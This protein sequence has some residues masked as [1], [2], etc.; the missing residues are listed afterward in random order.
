M[1]KK[2]KT[3]KIVK[4]VSFKDDD[5]AISKGAAA[6]ITVAAGVGLVGAAA[7]WGQGHGPFPLVQA[8]GHAIGDAISPPK[9][10]PEQK[11]DLTFE[12]GKAYTLS[13]SEVKSLDPKWGISKDA[14]SLKVTPYANNTASVIVEKQATDKSIATSQAFVDDANAFLDDAF[15]GK[16]IVK[17][18]H[19]I[20]TD[21]HI[22]LTKE[23]A[24]NYVKGNLSN[25]KADGVDTVDIFVNGYNGI[26][27]AKIFYTNDIPVKVALD[28]KQTNAAIEGLA[29]NVTK[30]VKANKLNIKAVHDNP[31]AYLATMQF[32]ED[33]LKVSDQWGL[34]L[35]Q[36][37]K[38]A[39]TKS[40]KYQAGYEAGVTDGFFNGTW[41]SGVNAYA[42]HVINLLNASTNASLHAEINNVSKQI[43]IFKKTGD[44]NATINYLTDLTQK[45]ARD[46]MVPAANFNGWVNNTDGSWTLKSGFE[47]YVPGSD[48][49]KAT[50]AILNQWRA[51]INGTYSNIGG[52]NYLTKLNITAG[53]LNSA[54]ASQLW[55]FSQSL[56]TAVMDDAKLEYLR[57]F[58]NGV[59][60]IDTSKMSES[61]IK[62]TLT[63][64]LSITELA[65]YVNATAKVNVTGMNASQLVNA[66]DTYW[67]GELSK[68]D[69]K[70]Y[71]RGLAE[72]LE[73]ATA[74]GL[75]LTCTDNTG[76]VN[77]TALDY[78]MNIIAST[79]SRLNY[80]FTHSLNDTMRFDKFVANLTANNVTLPLNVS[81]E[82]KNNSANIR[83]LD[84]CGDGALLGVYD[85][86]GVM[87]DVREL[88]SKQMDAVAT[89]AYAAGITQS[90]KGDE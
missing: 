87:V 31:L 26:G 70:G 60:G 83:I 11:S 75:L 55:N 62:D 36:I 49:A 46:G 45:V 48:V 17:D 40:D 6:A 30:L 69:R 56:H 42:T 57:G 72:R 67:T 20:P 3:Q 54:N 71:D 89:A 61:E 53:Q 23:K 38:N 22:V 9:K 79:S 13:S 80:T 28:Q 1:V 50:D 25:V 39:V 44:V 64:K 76:T 2:V 5:E 18:A 29:G 35:E 37:V 65:K 51:E 19:I 12:T 15:N 73:N 85:N 8:I 47:G 82:Y 32:V 66:L 41:T 4:K 52:T 77:G 74:S 63:S 58:A 81:F 43:D 86:R 14:T 21:G 34:D 16:K 10:A 78:R 88:T 24:Q 84:T 33:T 90:D 27:A 59:L 7:G 68:A